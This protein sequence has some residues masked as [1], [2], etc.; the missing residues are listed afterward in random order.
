MS[1]ASDIPLSVA[2]GAHA[3][4]SFVPDKRGATELAGY[5]AN[6]ERVY[7]LMRKHAEKG[8]TLDLLDEEFARYRGGLR[9]RTLAHLHSRG[10][11]MST[12]IAGPSNFPV[13]RMEKRSAVER[14]RLEELIAF[15]EYGLR[16]AIRNLRPDLRP[17]M[18]GDADALERLA[19]KIAEAELLQAHMKRVNL[20][21]TRYVKKPD[22][23]DR[24]DTLTDAE[25]DTIRGY[26]PGYSWEPHPF[27][28]FQLSNNN[29]NIRRMRERLE[30]IEVA[31][32]TPETQVAGVNGI[33][34]DDCPAENRVRLTF[35][36]KPDVE[37]RTRLKKNGFRW[38]PS[39]GV[40]QAYR[41]NW[42]LELARSIVGQELPNILRK[43]AE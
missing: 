16:A 39:L 41:N 30:S 34:L 1:Y 11:I 15:G 19:R 27:A 35:P 18:A 29:A 17:I 32:S 2:V 25:K 8:G 40:W 12:M 36:G 28:P 14:K 38:A 3:G 42:S 23:L 37:V 5:S 33:V 20:A 13:R 22:S 10:R 7:A 26:K 9:K 4:T 43:Q 31:Q 24:D 21:H 6:L